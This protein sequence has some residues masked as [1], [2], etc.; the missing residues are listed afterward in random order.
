MVLGVLFAAA[1]V[2]SPI[3][4]LLRRH[5]SLDDVRQFLTQLVDN[6]VRLLREIADTLRTILG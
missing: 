3:L 6:I 4:E 1:G 5:I 2:L